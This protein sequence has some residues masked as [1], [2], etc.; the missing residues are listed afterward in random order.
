MGDRVMTTATLDE[1]ARVDKPSAAD[2]SK[3][4]VVAARKRGSRHEATGANCEDAYS[5]VQ[6][7]PGVLVIAVADGCGS[8]SFA[9]IGANLAVEHGAAQ[10]CAGLEQAREQT[11]AT[12]DQQTIERILREAAAAALTAVQSEAATREV[13]YRELASTMILAIAHGEFIAAAQIGDGAIVFADETGG[14]F[15]LTVP[16]AGEYLNETVF[17]T[18]TDALQTMQVRIWRGRASGVAAFSDGLQMLCLKW[19]EYEPHTAFF[20]PLLSFVRYTT[21][22]AA[23]ANELTNFLHSERVAKLTDDDVTLVLAALGNDQ[24]DDKKS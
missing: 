21:D 18:S 19:P 9:E 8:V 23:A 12:P 3:W 2:T 10:V 20:T 17:L 6:P 13:D 7:L 1:G 14:L 11:E 24:D 22:E 5:V 4:Q 16:P 15:S